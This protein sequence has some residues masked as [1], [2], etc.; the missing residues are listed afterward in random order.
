MLSCGHDKGSFNRAAHFSQSD[1]QSAAQFV[2]Q[3]Y[4]HSIVLREIVQKSQDAHCSSK[5][6]AEQQAR[7]A[8][9]RAQNAGQPREWSGSMEGI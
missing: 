7:L 9:T 5:N 1:L 8:E 4:I 3:P 2:I 6:N